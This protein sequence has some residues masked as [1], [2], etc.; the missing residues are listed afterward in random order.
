MPPQLKT[1]IPL[2]V[3]FVAVFMVIRFFLIPESF[4][5]YGHY[6]GD[7]LEDN[8]SH[9]LVYAGK[10]ACLECHPKEAEMLEYDLHSELSCEVCHGPGMKHVITPE[11]KGL[12]V[13]PDSRKSC[14][15]C[16]NFHFARNANFIN[17]VDV[18]K[19]HDEKQK[20]IDCHNPHA[21][22]EMKE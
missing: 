1:L 16:H 3:L 14:G 11:I 9:A 6:R 21:V 10:G 7:A 5:E 17:Q 18:K 19:H 15:I 2:F 20:C 22:W 12:L 13:K 4:G 8:A